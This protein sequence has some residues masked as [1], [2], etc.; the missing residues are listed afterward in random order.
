MPQIEVH[1]DEDDQDD[2]LR[3]LRNWLTDDSAVRTTAEISLLEHPEQDGAM[4]SVL[5]AVQLVTENGWSAASFVL[6]LATWR[7]A[8]GRT[9]RITLRQGDIEV[10][11]TDASAAE[12]ERVIAALTG[13]DSD[14]PDSRRA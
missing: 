13:A 10:T 7:Q 11:L 14:Q 4:G 6:A 2:A 1:V 3:S 12:I 5:E 8:R 9:P